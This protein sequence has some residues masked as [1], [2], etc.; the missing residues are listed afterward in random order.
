MA[1]QAGEAVWLGNCCL[2]P[3]G[4][5][6]FLPLCLGHDIYHNTEVSGKRA[7]KGSIGQALALKTRRP[8]FAWNPTSGKLRE[9]QLYIRAQMKETRPAPLFTGC[10]NNPNGSDVYMKDFIKM[11]LDK[12]LCHDASLSY[13]GNRTKAEKM[14]VGKRQ[15]AFSSKS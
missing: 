11:T 9:T 15:G 7:G 12:S 8:E 1:C 10:V 6:D 13:D 14:R 3:V 4:H 5:L 2:C